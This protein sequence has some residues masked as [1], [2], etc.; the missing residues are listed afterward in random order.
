MHPDSP[1]DFT[2]TVYNLTSG[3]DGAGW[4]KGVKVR[5]QGADVVARK[6]AELMQLQPGT[7]DLGVLLSDGDFKLYRVT[8]VAPPVT[9][10]VAEV[11][12][13]SQEDQ[14]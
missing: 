3:A 14:S 13:V 12:D 11:V 2:A 5:Q 9:S 6:G 4:I 7:Y 1:D 8:T 10:I